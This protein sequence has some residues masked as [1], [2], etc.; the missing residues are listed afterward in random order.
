MYQALTY[1]RVFSKEHP[2]DL[3]ARLLGLD[4]VQQR[5]LLDVDGSVHKGIYEK[6]LRGITNA[7]MAVYLALSMPLSLL[8]AFVKE[9]IAIYQYDKKTLGNGV[10][11]E[12]REEHTRYLVN[13][14]CDALQAVPSSLV[15]R[16]AVRMPKLAYPHARETISL[17]RGQKALISCGVQ[18][19]VDAYGAYLGAVHRFGNPI[20]GERKLCGAVDK[21]RIASELADGVS[22]MH[23]IGDTCDDVGMLAAAKRHN[24]ESVAIALHGRSEA[25]EGSAD[26]IAGSWRELHE[27]ID[28]YSSV[29]LF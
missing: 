27:V 8:P 18:E 5:I 12:D 25:L 15:E 4:H 2:R 10:A 29:R 3:V 1:S 21:E 13:R 7:D 11:P 6:K 24:P 16:A 26:I 19:V 22:R 20:H 14:F 28:N 17:F 9:N 23:I